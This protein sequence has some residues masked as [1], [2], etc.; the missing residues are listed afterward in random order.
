MNPVFS[1]LDAARDAHPGIKESVCC[2]AWV[3]PSAAGVTSRTNVTSTP[4]R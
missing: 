4:L 3:G 2:D 1:L